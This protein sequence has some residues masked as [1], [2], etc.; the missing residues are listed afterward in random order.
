MLTEHGTIE[1]AS[2]RSSLRCRRQ[3]IQA[4]PALSLLPPLS[5]PQHENCGIHHRCYLDRLVCDVHFHHCIPVQPEQ[6]VV[7]AVGGRH[8]HP[9]VRYLPP[10]RRPESPVRP[11]HPFFTS[12]IHDAP[13]NEASPD[14][15][16]IGS[17]HSRWLCHFHRSLPLF[18]CLIHY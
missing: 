17:S 9:S 15:P 14:T 3:R 12:Y 10:Y 11:R 8:L 6:Q 5:R 4:F 2:R 18:A 16:A 1:L 7:G 13:Q